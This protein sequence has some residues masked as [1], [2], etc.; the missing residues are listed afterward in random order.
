MLT[1]AL[2][3]MVSVAPMIAQTITG[4]IT[5]TVSDPSG[6]LIPNVKVSAANAATGV[7]FPSATNAAGVYNILFL[8]P[9]DYSVSAEAARFRKAALGPFKLEADQIARVDITLVVGDVNQ[10]LE[11]TSVA[12]ILQTESTATGDALTSTKLTSLPLNG[13]NFVS[14]LTL[15][16]G[17]ITTSP[18]LVASAVRYYTYGGRPQVNGNRET[19]NT[20]LL[21]GVDVTESRLNRVGYQPNVDALEEVKVITGNGGAEFGNASGASVIMTLKGGANDF[22]GSAF[23][24]LRNDKLD[25]NGFFNNRGGA[26]RS[27]LRINT[28]GGTW[29]GPLRRNKAFFFVDYEGTELRS[30]SS[31]LGNV[32]PAAWRAGDLSS[33]LNLRE[34]VND[35]SSGQ[36]FPG[37]RIPTSRIVN[38]VATELFSGPDLYPLPNNA[39]TGPAGVQGNYLG[40][41]GTPLSNHQGDAKADWRPSAGDTVSGH[42]SI[43]RYQQ[44]GSRNWMPVLMTSGTFG[45]PT[46]A[47]GNWTRV[48][49]PRWVGDARVAFT[50]I[51]LDE[52]AV[53]DWSGKLGPDG[54][55]RFGIA[56]GQPVPGLS[57][58][59]LGDGLTPI[60]NSDT[61]NF[62]AENKYQIQTSFTFQS[63]GHVVKFGGQVVRLQ[64]NAT[65]PGL[66]GLLGSFTFTNAYSG[67][68]FGD[69]LLNTLTRKARG[70]L[71]GMRGQRQWRDGIFAQDDWKLRHY[72]TLNLGLRWEYLSPYVEA[73]DRQLNI[74][75]YT[76]ELQFPATSKHGRALYK[77]YYKEFMP[78]VGVA[79]TPESLRG[80]L[81]MR[82]GYRFA[83]FLEGLPIGSRLILN[84][85][86]LV[87]SDITYGRGA[88]GDIRTGFSDT[89]PRGS[90]TGPRTGPTPA[91]TIYAWDFNLRPQ[92]SSQWNFALEG[93]IAPSTSLNLTYVGQ[94][95]TRLAVGRDAN[96]PLPGA[97]PFETWAP[98]DDRRPL[99]AVLPNVGA[100]GYLESAGIMSYQALQAGARR[101]LSRGLEFLA[102]YTLSK[103][104]ADGFLTCAGV[105]NQSLFVQNAYNRR[106]DFG[107]SCADALHSFSAGALFA[108]PFGKGKRFGSSWPRALDR[109]LGGWTIN[110]TAGAHSGFPVT[111]FATGFQGQTG[112]SSVNSTTRPNRYRS[113][114]IR[115]QTVD[116]WFGLAVNAICTANGQDSGT[117]AYGLPARGTFGNAG[118]GTERTPAYFSMDAS[119]AKKFAVTEKQ[120]L[121]FRGEFFNVLNHVSFGPP[122]RDISTPATF[123]AIS[124]QAGSPRNIQFGLKY[125]F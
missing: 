125:L 88:P 115:D 40:N 13:R 18:N 94:R 87:Q 47:V 108:L 23:E 84:P 60:G 8:P 85:P 77:P 86:F 102:S 124:S 44:F 50:R 52:G 41:A 42:W 33:L 81:V 39:G 20:F 104:L 10:S 43:G 114:P 75:V 6:G 100:V 19:A 35:P 57:A 112:Q 105:D 38:P 15:L 113:L 32:A 117:C 70:D 3:L 65:Y 63:G 55:A 90:I 76:G 48:F 25:A 93:R 22:H 14:L 121:E 34:V 89:I 98:A 83:A 62:T 7:S 26:P 21:D 51:V 16:P 71:A 5:G 72:L 120:Y 78:I 107:P 2:L 56:G 1:R 17:T 64:Q 29:G 109:L 95:G 106:A 110:Q 68:A 30:S 96:Q 61:S 123:G 36:P 11:V 118:V 66:N 119:L 116:H 28:F 24:F 101:R 12:P 80:N 92:S 73:A 4:S 49:S 67:S 58:V 27:P 79:W 82:A 54:N 69:F 111:I 46:S 122:G 74:D 59:V 37:N 91:Y 53:V 103:S 9:G 99:A 45:S 31:V 97:G